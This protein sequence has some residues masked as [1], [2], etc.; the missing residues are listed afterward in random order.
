[1]AR[2]LGF[3]STEKMISHYSDMAQQLYVDP[4]DRKKLV[5]GL[6]E[7]GSVHN[8][9]VQFR[10]PDQGHIWVAIS[11]FLVRD[12]AGEPIRIEGLVSDISDRKQ[13]EHEREKMFEQL[14]Q[15]QKLEGVGQL[16]GGVA[17]DFNNMLAV[18]LGHTQLALMDIEPSEP[19]CKT[20]TEIQNAA[21][22]SVNL[23]RQLLA[24]ARKQTV[25]PKVIDLNGA[26]EGTYNL[27]RRLINEDIKFSFHP[28]AEVW[29]VFIDPD[30]IGQI[31]TNLCINARDAI[32]GIGEIAIA[33]QNV[34]F[35]SDYCAN[36]P[37]YL[38]G[39]YVC[40]SV[41]DTGSGMDKTTQKHIFE[42][43]YTTKGLH[44]GTGLG[45][46]TVYGIVKQNNAFIN[47]YS[48]P[49]QGTTFKIYFPTHAGEIAT[50]SK[51][52]AAEPLLLTMGMVLV[53]EDE[54]R[55]L[56]IS[57]QVLEE[58][59]CQVLAAGSPAEAIALAENQ[60]YTIDLLMTDV[61][62]PEMNGRELVSRI[63]QIRPEIRCLYM[64]G[65][66]ADIIAHKGV[67][68]MG[69]HFIQKPF[70]IQALAAKIGEVMRQEMVVPQAPHH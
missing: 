5:A 34:A 7:T 37:D 52:E 50:P 17:H 38:P 39:N 66:T 24:F 11:A 14:L 23:T 62:M 29:P 1:M 53:V 42:P 40:L 8:M 3:S 69:I 10:R 44:E 26:I 33:T 54:P 49:G 63:S 59:G 65:Y 70:S 57:K 56:N 32:S 58:L 30:Q 18:I 36:F 9:E 27:L 47:L 12:S 19:F 13:A 31:L 48:E 41:S 35:D 51:T 22:H 45:L 16:A 60:E 64:S 6:L 55:L 21:E 2:M 25:A 46:S 20:F 28:A 67:L 61:V 68:D 15:S 43:F 4:E